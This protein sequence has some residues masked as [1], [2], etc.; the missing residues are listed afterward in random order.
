MI[1][2]SA[3]APWTWTDHGAAF[4]AVGS[5]V[6]GVGSALLSPCH[7]GIIPLLGTHA[8]GYSPFTPRSGSGRD[9]AETGGA[10]PRLHAVRRTLLFTLGCFVTIPLFGLLFALLGH[11]LDRW[12]LAGVGVGASSR[13]PALPR[14][15]SGEPEEVTRS[16]LG[17][18]TALTG[19]EV[20]GASSLDPNPRPQGPCFSAAQQVANA[21]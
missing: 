3:L 16:F 6:W 15:G 5:F 20:R 1:D 11:G 10:A 17:H 13:N 4:V 8:A 9:E 18:Y 2:V 7:L 12:S 21:G 19:T 14:A